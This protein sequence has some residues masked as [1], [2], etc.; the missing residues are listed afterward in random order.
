LE[1]KIPAVR[2]DD[3]E[4]NE[5]NTLGGLFYHELGS[6]PTEGTELLFKGIKLIISKMD[7]QRIE[8]IKIILPE[9]GDNS[10]IDNHLK[11]D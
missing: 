1:E 4:S 11:A 8:E 9:T 6:V 7:A 5:Y 3:D 10:E 2:F